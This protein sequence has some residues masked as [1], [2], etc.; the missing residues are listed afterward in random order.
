[1]RY[2][3]SEGIYGGSG[4][5]FGTVTS[6]SLTGG[7]VWF[8]GGASGV[9]VAAPADTNEDTLATIAIPAL[10]VGSIVRVTSLFSVTNSANNKTLKVKVGT[11]NFASP[12]FTTV[13]TVRMVTEINIRASTSSQVASNAASTSAGTGS[14]AATT[15]TEA[16]GSASTMLITGQKASA[17]ETL[18]LESYFVEIYKP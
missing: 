5:R 12:V 15:G 4:Q 7:N 16:M 2:G 14:L 1:V 18:Q 6:I 9:A 10:S 8:I 3:G 11:T 17:G 13:A